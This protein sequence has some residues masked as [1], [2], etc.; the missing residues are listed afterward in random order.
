MNRLFGVCLLASAIATSTG[1]AQKFVPWHDPSKHGVQFVTVGEGVRLEVLD[2]GGTGRPV[3]LLAGSGN[4][5]HIFD[6]FAEKLSGS[7]CHVYGITRRGFGA[8]THPDSG[9]DQQRL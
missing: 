6:D 8:S 7:C 5:A 4:T 3:V 1:Y 9:Y 2:W